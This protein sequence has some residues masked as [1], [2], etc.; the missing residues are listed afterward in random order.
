MYKFRFIVIILI[1]FTIF[2]FIQKINSC[3]R[4]KKPHPN[5][6]MEISPAYSSIFYSIIRNDTFSFN[7]N[8]G[9]KKVFVIINVDSIVS[10]S[11]GP[12]INERPYKLLRMNFRELGEDTVPLTRS[13][14]VFINKYP[15]NGLHSLFI[16]FNNFYYSKDSVL[17]LIHL[18]TLVINGKAIASFYLLKSS[19]KL[20][21]KDDVELLFVSI[22]EG[23]VGF[24]TLSGEF[25]MRDLN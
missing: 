25:W 6:E 20:Y 8:K 5:E 23:I 21:H 1:S 9:L 18:D 19:L 15:D 2:F 14:E 3:F 17:P 4:I 11:K 13:N 16:Q 7:N 24:K 10:N 22:S 12:F